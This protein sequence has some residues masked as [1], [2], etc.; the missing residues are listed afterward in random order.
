MKFSMRN[1]QV[2]HLCWGKPV[3]V[4]SVG[5]EKLERNA[6]E[7]DLGVLVSGKSN[8]SQQCALAAQ[9]ATK[10]LTAPWGAPGPA[11]PQGEGRGCATLLCAAQPHLLHWVQLWQPQYENDITIR[12]PPKEGYEDSEGSRGQ[13]I[14]EVT[15]QNVSHV[16]FL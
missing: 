4:S 8:M 3:Y 16:L 14:W 10:G 1:C 5:D 12:E 2:L 7:R 11:L 6:M 9:R 15:T 13:N